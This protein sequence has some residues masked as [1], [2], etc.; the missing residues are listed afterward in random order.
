MLLSGHD[1]KAP[2]QSHDANCS[3]ENIFKMIQFLEDSTSDYSDYI[4]SLNIE[5]KQFIDM[6]N[7]IHDKKL[8][9]MDN[10]ELIKNLKDSISN[11]LKVFKELNKNNLEDEDYNVS[12]TLYDVKY[13]DKINLVMDKLNY[14][15]IS[16]Q[17]EISKI[18]H[19]ENA[20]PSRAPG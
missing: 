14:S 11:Y 8:I 12:Y 4:S 13:T 20:D 16:N 17:L 18:E 15:K 10:I 5:T 1:D 9:E 19:S 6:T 3:P 2:I 7:I